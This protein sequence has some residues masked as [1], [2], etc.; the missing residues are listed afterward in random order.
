MLTLV[1]VFSSPALLLIPLVSSSKNESSATWPVGNAAESAPDNANS[2]WQDIVPP[3]AAARSSFISPVGRSNSIT[4][5]YVNCNKYYMSTQTSYY[6]YLFP[7][8]LSINK[9]LFH[10]TFL[11]KDLK[12]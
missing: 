10:I 8:I 11:E 2:S 4:Q 6:D 5:N 12:Y 1:S 3:P 9:V 7:K